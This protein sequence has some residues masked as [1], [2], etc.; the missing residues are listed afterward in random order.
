MKLYELTAF[1]TYSILYRDGKRLGHV[2]MDAAHPPY[3]K[4]AGVT[5]NSD[6]W[7]APRSVRGLT[8][9]KC[10]RYEGSER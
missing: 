2:I 10:K 8:G 3:V 4:Y 6:P 7:P 5:D 1:V 9:W